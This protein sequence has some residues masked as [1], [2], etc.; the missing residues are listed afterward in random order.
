LLE[1]GLWSETW[2]KCKIFEFFLFGKIS[3]IYKLLYAKWKMRIWATVWCIKHCDRIGLLSSTNWRK[4]FNQNFY[5]TPTRRQTAKP[6]CKHFLTLK[7][8]NY[9]V[10]SIQQMNTQS[11]T[12]KN[13]R[14]PPVEWTL[15]FVEGACMFGPIS[16]IPFLNCVKKCRPGSYVLCGSFSLKFCVTKFKQKSLFSLFFTLKFS[17]NL[18]VYAPKCSPN[19]L[20]LFNIQ[21]LIN[22][23]NFSIKKLP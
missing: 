12:Q 6:L 2:K 5:L 15:A 21:H 10:T 9:R 1:S 18:L 13:Q 4:K 23:R 19:S 8:C 16:G 7:F 17:L 11:L 14:V 20:L 3:S 22:T